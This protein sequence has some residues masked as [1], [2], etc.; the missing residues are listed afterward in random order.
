MK[1][2]DKAI[3]FQIMV[4]LRFT[5][6]TYFFF[7]CGLSTLLAKFMVALSVSFHYNNS[8]HPSP[9]EHPLKENGVDFFSHMGFCFEVDIIISHYVQFIKH[10]LYT[11][12]SFCYFTDSIF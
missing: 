8:Y 10:H 6:G 4:G 7:L 5:L 3:Q 9:S 1:K 11:Y 12:F 2:R